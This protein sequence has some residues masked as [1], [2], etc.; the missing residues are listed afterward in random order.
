LAIFGG[1]ALGWLVGFAIYNGG[2]H[3]RLHQF[4]VG[5]TC[6]LLMIAAGLVTKGIAAFESDHWNRLTGAQSDDEGTY[7]PRVNV[8]ALKCCDPKQ[9]DSE[10]WGVANSLLGWSNIASYW[11]IGS[12]ILYWG[13]ISGWLIHSKNKREK[14][15]LSGE[16]RPLLGGSVRAGSSSNNS[17]VEGGS[18][19]G[20]SAGITRS[21]HNEVTV[22]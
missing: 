3:M 4:F 12:Y 8:W 2:N 14:K 18:G 9:P 15:A 7:D 17:G 1:L 20:R 16:Q 19:V 13:A 11:T 6:L 22:A 21:D 5:S 10:W